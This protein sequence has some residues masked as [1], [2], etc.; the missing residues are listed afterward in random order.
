MSAKK[1][2]DADVSL[3]QLRDKTIAVVGYGIQGRAQ[4]NN[5][6]DSGLNVIIGLYKKQNRGNLPKMMD[7]L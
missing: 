2:F 3:E 7:T 1:W 4:A 6:K 5:M